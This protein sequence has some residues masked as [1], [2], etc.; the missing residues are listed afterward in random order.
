MKEATIILVASIVLLTYSLS[1]FAYLL[2]TNGI[3]SESIS[4]ISMIIVGIISA[5]IAQTMFQYELDIKDR[6]EVEETI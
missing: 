5:K 6:K 3:F 1:E 4:L 2:I